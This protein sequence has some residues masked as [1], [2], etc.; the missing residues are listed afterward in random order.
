MIEW[1]RTG[2]KLPKNLLTVTDEML[3]EWETVCD[4]C[5]TDNTSFEDA[6]LNAHNRMRQD[7]IY[8]WG[9]KSKVYKYVMNAVRPYKP[10]NEFELIRHVV[11]KTRNDEEKRLSEVEKSNEKSKLRGKAVEYLLSRGRKINEDFEVD[12]ALS[13][14]NKLAYEEEKVRRITRI[15]ES[16]ILTD[17]NGQNCEECDGWDGVSRRCDCGNRRVGWNLYESD[18]FFLGPFIYG[19]AY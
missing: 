14:A 3:V 13:E 18:D 4:E 5:N 2:I 8:I 1:K 7:A 19:E 11:M 9:D 17:F 12:W 6:L 16:G 10:E 15:A